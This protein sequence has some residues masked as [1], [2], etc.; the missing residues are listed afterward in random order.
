MVNH[1]GR[2]ALSFE[3]YCSAAKDVED[4][5]AVRSGCHAILDIYATSI[6]QAVAASGAPPYLHA[7]QAWLT[8]TR[9]RCM[10]PSL[11]WE[12]LVYPL[13]KWLSP[14]PSTQAR[15]SQTASG[16]VGSFL[17]GTLC[18]AQSRPVH[19]SPASYYTSC[20]ALYTDF[21]QVADRSHCIVSLLL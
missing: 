15:L 6:D 7:Q 9:L 18:A 20:S 21:L 1:N 3:H 17:T 16:Q 8:P 4:S 11:C 5:G 13:G 2:S 19:S 10:A 14:D 12:C